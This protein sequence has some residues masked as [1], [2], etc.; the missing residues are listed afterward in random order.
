MTDQNDPFADRPY[1]PP[2]QRGAGDAPS[3]G[4]EGTPGT[5]PEQHL[6]QQPA[7]AQITPEQATGEPQP[8]GHPADHEPTVQ[9]PVEQASAPDRTGTPVPPEYAHRYEA[10]AAPAAGHPGA[11]P[12]VVLP[13]GAGGSQQP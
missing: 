1:S 3:S 13:A 7:D 4:A 8:G 6:P 10:P 12:T 9:T 2:T 11:E 5:A